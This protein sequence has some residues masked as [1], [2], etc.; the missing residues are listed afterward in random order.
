MKVDRG[1]CGSLCA[2]PGSNGVLLL[3]YRCRALGGSV[4]GADSLCARPS[5]S[6]GRH[7][8]YPLL[9]S[10]ATQPSAQV[11]KLSSADSFTFDS[12]IYRAAPVSTAHTLLGYCTPQPHLPP[13]APHPPTP[14][15]LTSTTMPA[16]TSHAFNDLYL[17]EAEI[18]SGKLTPPFVES[19]KVLVADGKLEDW[20]GPVTNIYSPIL[21]RSQTRARHTVNPP[22]LTG[23]TVACAT[24]HR[25]ST[26]RCCVRYRR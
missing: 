4:R 18:T 24:A 5:S 23:C 6:C 22:R 9:S 12:S 10:L 2:A 14:P 13:V 17:D 19:K 3:C 21:K 1:L 8:W 16:D 11:F 7:G 15:L 26:R 20:T 25:C